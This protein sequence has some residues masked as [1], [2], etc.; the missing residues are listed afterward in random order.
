MRVY[1]GMR[2]HRWRECADSRRLMPAI[3]TLSKCVVK[4]DVPSLRCGAMLR[5]NDARRTR[6]DKRRVGVNPF[7]RIFLL[8]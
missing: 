7:I 6:E 3:C 8:R 1:G 4:C 2:A 5:L